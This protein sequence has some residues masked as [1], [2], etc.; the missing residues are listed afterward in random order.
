MDF[1]DMPKRKEDWVKKQVKKCLQSFNCYYTMPAMS[2]YGSSGVPDFLVCLR[3]I[4]I[5]IECKAGSNTPTAL[6]WNNLINIEGSGG[7][8]L[9]INEKS[10]EFL[11]LNLLFIVLNHRSSHTFRGSFL[12]QNH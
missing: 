2:G 1:N 7:W 5:G 11:S 8:S 10:V 4:F 12:W 3:G 6:Q 9:V